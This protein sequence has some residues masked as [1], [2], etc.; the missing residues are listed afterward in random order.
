M[1]DAKAQGLAKQIRGAT[2]SEQFDLQNYTQSQLDGL[3]VAAFKDPIISKDMIA[4]TFIVGGGK[5]VRQKYSP[6]MPKEFSTALRDKVGFVED[7]GAGCSK[8]CQGSFKFQ[9]D[10]DKDL[11]TMTV[12]PRIKEPE[13][14][15]D[16]DDDD[17]EDII[18]VGLSKLHVHRDDHAM[19]C[20][21]ADMDDFKRLVVEYCP[22]F[23]QRKALLK[24]LKHIETEVG[25]IEAKL[26]RSVTLSEAEDEMY[27]NINEINDK[28]EGL[29]KQVE[30]M[31]SRGQLAKGEIKAFIPDLQKKTVQL[32]AMIAKASEKGKKTDKLELQKQKI[33]EKVEA[34]KYAEGQRPFYPVNVCAREIDEELSGL[35][36]RQAAL[37]TEDPKLEKRIDF[38]VTKRSGWY[39]EMCPKEA[40][41]APKRVV[42]KVPASQPS[43]GGW[44]TAGN[45]KGG[46]K[47]SGRSAAASKGKKAANLFAMLGDDD[48][49]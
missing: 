46:S 33:S 18:T 7:R 29:S 12:Y 31:M 25:E 34:L 10:T 47:R 26:A 17:Y 20:A 22:S 45:S 49:Y 4:F 1:G 8:D 36:K 3:T 30:S 24:A 2:S 14:K 6:S 43:G 28:I 21:A 37:F 40:V 32:E 5:K 38:L 11:K 23:S 16:D 9:H 27:N 19:V 42:K 41:V 15:E 44:S 13:Q 48:D 39:S 35:R